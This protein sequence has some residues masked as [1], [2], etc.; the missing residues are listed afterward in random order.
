MFYLTFQKNIG[1]ASAFGMLVIMTSFALTFHYY[2]LAFKV[3]C[4]ESR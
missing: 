4:S 3:N 1:K 2:I